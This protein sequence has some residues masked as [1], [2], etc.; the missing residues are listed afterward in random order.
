MSEDS[1]QHFGYF[2]DR[3]MCD[4]CG[5]LHGYHAVYC[6]RQRVDIDEKTLV[7]IRRRLDIKMNDRRS[8][9]LRGHDDSVTG[10]NEAWDLMRRLLDDIAAGK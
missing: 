10:F 5:Y 7:S 9:M 4:E 8:K 3:I 2:G 6:T 1:D